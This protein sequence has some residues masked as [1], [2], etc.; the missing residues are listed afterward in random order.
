MSDD[1]DSV[2]DPSAIEEMVGELGEEEE[3]SDH[4]VE[5]GEGEE[6]AL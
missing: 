2:I 1:N 4:A 6:D 3:D 5:E